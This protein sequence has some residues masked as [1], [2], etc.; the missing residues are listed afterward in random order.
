[1]NVLL[2][3]RMFKRW[4]VIFFFFFLCFL[5]FGIAS[6]TAGLKYWTCGVFKNISEGRW[7]QEWLQEPG[8]SRAGALREARH[9]KYSLNNAEAQIG[10]GRKG[11][12]LK[13]KRELENDKR[14]SA[15]AT[16]DETTCGLAAHL[17]FN[18]VLIFRVRLFGFRP[19]HSH[20]DAK[21]LLLRQPWQQVVSNS[22]DGASGP[23]NCQQRGSECDCWNT[24]ASAHH[25]GH[26]RHKAWIL[27]E[28][29]G[30]T[31]VMMFLLWI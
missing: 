9:Q 28:G 30:R 2:L 13:S 20:H 14:Q 19:P 12:A 5:P 23:F 1:M 24:K 31:T 18:R 25:V 17:H 15:G 7:E 26:L 8:L 27:A 22:C 16:L 6:S 10:P 3:N 4:A 29:H 21:L 11:G